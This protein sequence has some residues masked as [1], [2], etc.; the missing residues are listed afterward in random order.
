MAALV[1][2]LAGLDVDASERAGLEVALACLGRVRAWLDG[3]EVAIAT[4]LGALSSF[5]EKNLSDAARV[6]LRQ[7]SRVI[8]RA[9]TAGEATA[10]G[11]SLTAGRISGAH[12]DALGDTLRSLPDRTRNDL[13]ARQDTLL[14][15]AE[16]A[17]PDEFARRLRQETNR[18]L[19][20]DDREERLARQRRQ[21]RLTTWVD[22]TSGMGHWRAVWDPDTMRQLDTTLDAMV[23]RLF[24]SSHPD[25]CPTDPSERQQFLRAHALLAIID[26][27]GVTLAAPE[28]VIVIHGDGNG[29][30]VIDYELPLDLPIS[31]LGD[32]V[33]RAE[34]T[35]IV[36]SPGTLHSAPGNLNPGAA[37][38]LANRDQRRALRALYRTCAIPGC[39]TP[40]HRTE[41]HHLDPYEHSHNSNIDNLIPICC[42][43]HDTLH[44]QHWQLHLTPD[45]TLT[46]TLPDQTTM[47]TG[48]PTR[49]TA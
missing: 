38:R 8:D 18:L 43:H 47:T 2:R 49:H 31:V 5:P 21:T 46:V 23:E 9:D 13:L 35:T 22:A 29:R 44:Q 20:D 33:R 16:Q 11:E 1:A 17:T 34:I 24:H 41:I 48:P 30:A 37:A 27:G 6:S 26:G 12:V 45:R 15:V 40:F 19:T 28:A 25:H 32:L 42:H 10:F 39:Q 4:R 7:A 36:A 3:R 14:R